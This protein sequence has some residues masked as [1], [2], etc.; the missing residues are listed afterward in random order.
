MQYSIYILPD[1]KSTEIN[2]SEITNEIDTIKNR[3]FRI[4]SNNIR[5]DIS[6]IIFKDNCILIKLSFISVILFKEKAYFFKFHCIESTTFIKSINKYYINNKNRLKY[7]N[8][9]LFIFEAILIYLSNLNDSY[10]EK[11]FN[12]ISTLAINNFNTDKLKDILEFQHS[13]LI[14][15]NKCQEYFESLMIIKENEN[16]IKY[17]NKSKN[18]INDNNNL[19]IK[20]NTTLCL[21]NKSVKRNLKN[22]NITDILIIYINQIKEDIKNLDRLNN[23]IEN[24]IDLMNVKLSKIRIQYANKSLYLNV[25]NSAFSYSC[26]LTF[27]FGVNIKNGMENEI[28]VFYII[29]ALSIILNVPIYFIIKKCFRI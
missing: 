6:N 3:D 26:F 1:R 12:Y 18:N 23:E 29:F 27:M 10:L 24:Y 14:E 19:C 11:Q 21:K 7:I 13:I 8:F 25:I 9:E 2:K 15:K 5:S 22:T 16:Y 4:F 20:N 28:Y 17:F